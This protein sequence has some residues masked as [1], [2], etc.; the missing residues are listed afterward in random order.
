M[1]PLF[2]ILSHTKLYLHVCFCSPLLA[3]CGPA[4]IIRAARNEHLLSL[5][6]LEFEFGELK[7]SKWLF[8]KY[9]FIFFL[10]DVMIHR[11]C[12]VNCKRFLH[13]LIAKSHTYYVYVSTAN[14]IQQKIFAQCKNRKI[15]TYVF[16][17]VRQRLLPSFSSSASR[18]MSKCVAQCGD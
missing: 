15:F 12:R 1:Q 3:H 9:S 13:Q 10:V 17:Q 2:S 6:L 16:F 14:T 18:E 4:K 7:E 8:G 5:R 11:L